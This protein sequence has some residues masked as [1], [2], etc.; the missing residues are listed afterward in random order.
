MQDFLERPFV[1]ENPSTYVGFTGSTLTEWEFINR[2]A[3][4]ADCGLLLDVNNVY[5][6]SVNH[7]FDPE[8]FIRSVPHQRVVQFHLAGHTNCQTHLID[9]H[10]DHVI[11]PVWKLYR[12]AHELTGGVST[13]LE[14][15]AKIPPFPV[16]H[17]EVLKAKQHI[18]EE[19]AGER[20]AGLAAEGEPSGLGDDAVEALRKEGAVPHPL[21]HA[22][23][24]VE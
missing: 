10:D 24:E 5:V 22:A 20:M 3:E 6:S 12:L 17:A 23:A 16:L 1:L 11:D 19:L 8:T 13:L 4:E 15:D 2:M 21:H 14:W 18:G 9:T 7:D